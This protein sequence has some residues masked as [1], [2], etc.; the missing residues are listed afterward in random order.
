MPLFR[1]LTRQTWRVLMARIFFHLVKIEDRNGALLPL[2]DI[3]P[4]TVGSPGDPNDI[5]F[6]K[7]HIPWDRLCQV[8]E[9]L[10]FRKVLKCDVSSTV[11]RQHSSN[12]RLS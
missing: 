5:L 1:Q 12:E 6:A 4:K 2:Q 11:R 10:Q 8:A 3:S 9:V 7:L